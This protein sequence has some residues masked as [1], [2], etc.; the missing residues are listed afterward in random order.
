LLSGALL[1]AATFA[2]GQGFPL[3]EVPSAISEPSAR[4]AYFVGHY[5]D[6]FPF[7]D[8]A[9]V[10]DP[11]VTEQGFADFVALL[12]RGDE[13]V[14][15]KAVGAFAKRAFAASTPKAVRERFAKLAEH[16]L[17][18]PDSP[19]RDD[20]LYVLF[21]R[22]LSG[23]P[24]FTSAQRGLWSHQLEIAS[25]NLPG[26]V[27]TDFEYMDR[28][29]RFGTLHGTE[30]RYIVLYFNDPDCETCHA[31]TKWMS[32]EPLFTSDP[33]LT[34]LAVYPDADTDLWLSHPQPFP[35]SWIDACSPEGE[36][37]GRQL[38]I[39]RATPTIFLLDSDKRV[40]LKDPSPE[41]LASTLRSLLQ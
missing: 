35:S 21:L 31:V 20:A 19:M 27:A 25:K 4:F 40:L 38:Y 14:A 8:E 23:S 39:I 9:V 41:S 26:T 30:G 16:Y 22:R 37:S 17:W 15:D 10:E 28:G 2:W 1:L 6:A 18:N 36:V 11:D 7:G 34:V 24:S 3:P 5:W 32:R 33:R 13:S 29:G 12:G